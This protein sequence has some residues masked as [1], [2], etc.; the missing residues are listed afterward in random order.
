MTNIHLLA[1]VLTMTRTFKMASLFA[2]VFQNSAERQRCLCSVGV[3]ILLEKEHQTCRWTESIYLYVFFFP[4]FFLPLLRPI[5]CS[6]LVISSFI[7]IIL[8]HI[9]VGD[10]DTCIHLTVVCISVP[11]CTEVWFSNSHTAEVSSLHQRVPYFYHLRGLQF[12]ILSVF[13]Y[14]HCRRTANA[15][16]VTGS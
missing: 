7:S 13:L 16:T 3:L 11:Y 15:D 12:L 9:G 5:L 1:L 4:S 8:A 14:F 6:F 2:A 10:A